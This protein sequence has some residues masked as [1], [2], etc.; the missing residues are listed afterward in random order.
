[1]IT[2]IYN[3]DLDRNMDWCYYPYIKLYFNLQEIQMT[4]FVLSFQELLRRTEDEP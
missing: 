4:V 3:V 2:G 1:M